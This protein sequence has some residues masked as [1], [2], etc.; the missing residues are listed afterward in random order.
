MPRL[1]RSPEPTGHSL[2]AKK[3]RNSSIEAL[4]IIAM[5]LIVLSHAS[6]HG[7][8]DDITASL[9]LNGLLLQWI[10]LGG[11]G[12]NIFILISGYFL[13]EMK[14]KFTSVSRLLAQGWFYSL[15]LFLVCRFGFGYHYSLSELLVVFLPTLFYEYWF[16]T[17]YLIILLLSPFIN[18]MLSVLSQK[19]HLQ[20]IFTT[21]IM[22]IVIRTLT[23]SEVLGTTVPFAFT[24]YTI[25]AYFR[26]YPQNWFSKPSHRI[27]LTVSSFA[28]LF[29]AS[30]AL[31][32]LS[33]KFPVLAGKYAFLYDKNSL[34]SVT[35]GIGLFSIFLYRKPF[36]SK[37]INVISGCT[38]GVYL[39]HE[40][41]IFQ[42]FIWKQFLNNVPYGDSPT[43]L[44][45]V[46]LSAAIVFSCATVIEFL[47]Q[48]TVDKPLARCVDAALRHIGSLLH[49]C[50]RHILKY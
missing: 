48:K 25:G 20:L 45:R 28:L 33:L 4:R 41:P 10:T 22:W 1:Q 11:V 49:K 36:Y 3:E 26:K 29:L 43:L 23:T 12:V 35:C 2:P 7:G 5:L 17:A 34:F 8:F 13:C 37:W 38:F 19:Q 44:P 21:F 50:A 27:F 47:R 6:V 15:V 39:I 9:T 42:I 32:I 16:L 18:A 40:N 46:L 24:I 14:F 30:L 31:S